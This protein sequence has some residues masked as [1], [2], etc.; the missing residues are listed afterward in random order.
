[1]SDLLTWL[2]MVSTSAYFSVLSTYL[3][4]TAASPSVT[5]AQTKQ[6]E[7][8]E[9]AVRNAPGFTLDRTGT[10]HD[11]DYFAGGWTTRQR[12]LR[13]RGAGSNDW[14]EFPGILCMALYLDGE[15]TV[16]ELYFPTKRSAGLTLRTF[17]KNKKQWSIYWVNSE[18]GKLDPVPV[19]GGFNGSHGEFYAEDHDQQRAIAVRYVWN[20]L[21]RD[22][23]VWEQAF[24]Y[25]GRSWETNWKADFTRADASKVCEGNRPKR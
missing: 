2:S 22:H 11:F 25:D 10:I 15:A 4:L 19:V 1:M 6:P 13:V 7:T 12:R 14:E 16:D 17:D 9:N 18:T 3:M 20:L 21:D 24:S 23:A 5:L 8:S